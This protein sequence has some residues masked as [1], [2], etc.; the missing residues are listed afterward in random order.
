MLEK[1][2]LDKIPA[3]KISLF[4]EFRKKQLN[5]IRNIPERKTVNISEIKLVAGADVS[6]SNEKA[7][8]G[9][10]VLKYPELNI[11]EVSTHIFTP[12]IPYVPTFLAFRELPGLIAAFK[13]LIKKPDILLVDGNGILHH[14]GIGLATHLGLTI[15]LPTMGVAKKLLLGKYDPSEL[16]K[17][18]DTAS[19]IHNGEIIG[20]ALKTL[21]GKVIYISVGRDITLLT[22]TTL[23]KKCTPS[24]LPKPIQS[25]HDATK[26][27]L[28]KIVHL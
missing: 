21:T 8:A 1:W 11:I 15:N 4:T 26:E 19:I 25:I 28:S 6:Y 16:N 5:L 14:Y 20:N 27:E 22:A 24:P 23:V 13:K 9:I 18:M 12:Q 17:S 7:C 3:D 10:A 2:I